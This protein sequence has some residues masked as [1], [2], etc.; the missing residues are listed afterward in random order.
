[1]AS[2]YLGLISGTSADGIDVA[3]ASFARKPKLLASLTHAY[4]DDLRRRIL[5]LAQGDGRIALDEFGALDVE[6]ARSFA[7]AASNLLRREGVDAKKIRALGSHGQTVRHRPLGPAPYTMQLGDPNVIAEL[8]GITTVADFRRRDIAAGGHGAPL[9]P[10]F[11]AAMLAQDKSASTKISRVVL[12]LGGIAN[13]TILPGNAKQSLRGFD[14]G[15][16]SCLLDAWIARH[17]D[18]PYDKDGAFAASG[19][20]D[21]TLLK[22]LLS[23]PYFAEPPPKSTGREVFHLSWLAKH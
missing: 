12:N 19:R 5:A 16:A 22:R 2:L 20:I 1:M 11:H 17:R 8:T 15:P 23:E 9:A 3:L 7:A 13:I 6:I 14:T 21:E 10:A 4:P 18:Q